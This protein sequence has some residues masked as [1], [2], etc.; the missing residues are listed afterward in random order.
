M[1]S[2]IPRDRNR[3]LD[4]IVERNPLISKD[5]LREFQCFVD[6]ARA[7]G[8]E[9]DSAY[10][11][12]SPHSMPNMEPRAESGRAEQIRSSSRHA[13]RR[14]SWQYEAECDWISNETQEFT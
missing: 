13:F 2:N 4:E 14:V 7:A 5:L 10:R 3:F 1:T 6:Q 11:L 9:F 12:V 8:V